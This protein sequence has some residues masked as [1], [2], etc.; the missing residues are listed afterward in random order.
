[1]IAELPGQQIMLHND[2]DETLKSLCF[3]L[4][5]T[6]IVYKT[7]K[8]KPHKHN[9]E[10]IYEGYRGDLCFFFQGDDERT[11]MFEKL[12]DGRNKGNTS[13]YILSFHIVKDEHG[14]LSVVQDTKY[15]RDDEYWKLQKKCREIHK[16]YNF[17]AGKSILYQRK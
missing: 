14:S 15:Q 5:G 12:I 4:P 8:I 2:T 6:D 13:A 17:I 7:K 1:M 16:N 3:Y 10:H 11:F 9:L